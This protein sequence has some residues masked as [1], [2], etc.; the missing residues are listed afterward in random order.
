MRH[1]SKL[2]PCVFGL[3]A[4]GVA[5]ANAVETWLTAERLLDVRSGRWIE[6]PAVLIRDGRIVSITPK[7]ADQPAPELA[8]RVTLDGMSIVPGLID[9]HVHLDFDPRYS[10]YSGLQFND[11]FWSVVMRVPARP[12]L[13]SSTSPTGARRKGNVPWS[14]PPNPC[15]IQPGATTFENSPQL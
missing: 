10:G 14:S 3:A 1:L 9:M 12:S 6:Q 13:R 11:R 4:F 5:D 15:S 2:L 7:A 8:R